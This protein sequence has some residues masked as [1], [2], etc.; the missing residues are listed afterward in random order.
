MNSQPHI[1]IYS[2]GFGVRKDD[3]GL[4]SDI[5]AGMPQVESILFDYYQAD[6]EQHILKLSSL[7]QQVS[8]L[9]DILT[10]TRLANPNAIIDIIGHS[11]GTIIPALAKVKGLRKTILL[12][13]VFDMGIQRTLD[14]YAGNPQ[15][16]INL[17]GISTLPPLDGYIRTV[18]P[19]YWQERKQVNAIEEFNKFAEET[20]LIAINANQDTILQPVDLKTLSSAIH[21]INMD[22]DHNFSGPAR[23]PL[24]ERIKTLL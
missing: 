1:I 14:R 17:E 15:A 5:A 7:N 2:H 20:E 10:Q 8:M 23:K 22:G 4:L 21:I 9:T 24:I 3:R 13:P 6:E 18:P 16:H 12:A 11:Q 19:E